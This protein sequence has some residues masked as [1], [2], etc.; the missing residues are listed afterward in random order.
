M[1]LK[2]QIHN[3]K[4]KKSFPIV[5]VLIILI[6]ILIV[7]KK[8]LNTITVA[9]SIIPLFYTIVSL[10]GI[11]L[12]IYLLRKHHGNIYT[13]IAYITLIIC[14]IIVLIDSLFFLTVF[15]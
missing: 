1:N 4:N 12:F 5:E 15:W 14:A 3:K 9:Y 11:F 13:K 2:K 7:L 10:F 6:L 8:I